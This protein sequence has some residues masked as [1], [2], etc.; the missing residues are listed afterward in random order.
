MV[1]VDRVTGEDVDAHRTM[2]MD[3]TS[4]IEVLAAPRTSDT[5]NR[6]PDEIANSSEMS[7]TENV[8]E[9]ANPGHCRQ[10][11]RYSTLKTRLFSDHAVAERR[12]SLARAAVAFA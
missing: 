11:H 4:A 9:A 3:A 1:P 6:L 8:A 10:A 2:R 5:M 12:C 7:A